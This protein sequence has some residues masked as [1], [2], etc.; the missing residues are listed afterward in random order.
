MT[1]TLDGREFDPKKPSIIIV[2][3]DLEGC[4]AY[5]GNS[6]NYIE[7]VTLDD[8]KKPFNNKSAFEHIKSKKVSHGKLL[9][10]NTGI[11]S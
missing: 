8:D 1:K 2:E 9:H 4:K 3:R 5:W 10:V 6:M 7:A 11:K